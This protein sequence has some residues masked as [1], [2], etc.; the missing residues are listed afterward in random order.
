MRHLL[1]HR[2]G[3]RDYTN[4]MFYHTV[5]GLKAVRNKVFTYQELI[6]LA[7]AHRSTSKPGTVYGYSHTNFVVLAELIERTDCLLGPAGRSRDLRRDGPE[8]VLR[9]PGD[10]QAG[11]R[12]T[13]AHHAGER[14]RRQTHHDVDGEHVQH[15]HHHHR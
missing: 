5:P 13:A 8:P 1:S 6:D 10:R 4:H 7:T 11:F 3:L 2:S 14:G 12:A 9:R 15:H